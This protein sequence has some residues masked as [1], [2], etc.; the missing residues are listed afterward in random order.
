MCAPAEPDALAAGPS[1]IAVA[2]LTAVALT[3]G[4]A[5][6]PEKEPPCYRAGRSDGTEGQIASNQQAGGRVR[7]CGGFQRPPVEIFAR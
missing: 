6:A 1:R 5:K 4:V 2:C 3:N 7:E